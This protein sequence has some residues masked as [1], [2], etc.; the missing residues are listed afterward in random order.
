MGGA[1]RRMCLR[2][3]K[4]NLLSPKPPYPI[5][6]KGMLALRDACKA[7]WAKD[8]CMAY[9]QDLEEVERALGRASSSAG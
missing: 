5:T 3:A 2:L 7:R 8:G 4:E 9:Q 6:L 1:Y